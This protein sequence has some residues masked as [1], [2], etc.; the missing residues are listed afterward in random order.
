MPL[1]FVEEDYDV[2][3]SS[4]FSS[5][6]PPRSPKTASSSAQAYLIHTQ[7]AI[8][9]QIASSG[10]KTKSIRGLWKTV[11]TSLLPRLQDKADIFPTDVSLLPVCYRDSHPKEYIFNPP[12]VVL[13][14]L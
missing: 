14:S 13:A 6:S 5:T 9:P 7:T 1:N 2:S 12:S 3:F 11:R 4:S 8:D 10:E